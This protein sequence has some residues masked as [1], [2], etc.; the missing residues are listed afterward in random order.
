MKI[1]ALN[2]PMWV[3]PSFSLQ[4]RLQ[5]EEATAAEPSPDLNR[6]GPV[7]KLSALIAENCP[8]AAP[9]G[10]ELYD[11][12]AC[13]SSG[14]E[15]EAYLRSSSKLSDQ[16]ACSSYGD[17]L[18]KPSSVGEPFR[19]MSRTGRRREQRKKNAMTSVGD[20]GG[21]SL[22]Q[23]AATVAR[24]SLCQYFIRFQ[25]VETARD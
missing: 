17:E 2:D 19:R 18:E 4:Q 5:S 25:R 13:F 21:V 7:L 11:Q 23:T 6:A 20:V 16:T 15:T 24:E 22:K 1:T 3:V 9:P 12:K 14:D 10:L 8:V